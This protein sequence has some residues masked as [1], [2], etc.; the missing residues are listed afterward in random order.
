MNSSETHQ[1]KSGRC[2]EMLSQIS[3]YVDGEIEDELC[4]EIEQ[5]LA[6]CSDCQIVV[7]TLSKTVKLYRSLAQTEVALPNDVEDRLLR[8]LNLSM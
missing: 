4:K 5:H 3:A 7:D 8:R 6:N 2:Y 1:H